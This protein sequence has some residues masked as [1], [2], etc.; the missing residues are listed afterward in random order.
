MKYHYII[1]VE[2][3]LEPSIQQPKLTITIFQLE[4]VHN[5]YETGASRH[6]ETQ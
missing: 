6:I 1:L 2:K 3:V 4:V 5:N